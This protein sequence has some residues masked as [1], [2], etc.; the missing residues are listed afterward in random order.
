[1]NITGGNEKT[2]YYLG[3]GALDQEGIVRGSDDFKRYNLRAKL[4][5]D[6]NDWLTV[7]TNTSWTNRTADNVKIDTGRGF[8]AAPFF[9]SKTEDGL[10]VVGLGGDSSNPIMTSQSGSYNLLEVD[11]FETQ[12]FAK[13]K[14][15]K[16]LTFEEKVS[17]KRSHV[18]TES[19]KDAVGYVTL[20]VDDSGYTDEIHVS[21]T[22]TDRKLS[23]ESKKN[24]RITTQSFLRYKYEKNDHFFKGLLGFQTEENR[25]EGFSAGTFDFLNGSLQ[26]LDLGA[27]A[28]PDIGGGKGSKSSASEWSIVSF[29]G[30]LNYDYKSKYMAEVSFRYDGTSRFADSKKWGF[31]PSVS[32]GW[33]M[34]NEN[35]MQDVEMLDM[36]KLRASWGQLGDAF[37]VGQNSIYQTM[38]QNAGY[39]WPD[40]TRPGIATG[41]ASN[42]NITWETATV[43]NF[44]IDASFWK[45]KLGIQSEYFINNRTDILGTPDVAK[46]FG[47]G[48]PAQNVRDVRSWGWELSISHKNKIGKL[49]Y[50]VLV[51]LSDQKNKV[52]DLGSTTPDIGNRILDKGYAI[53]AHYGYRSDGLITSPEDLN[54][55]VSTYSLDGPLTPYVGS[56]KL[57]DISGPEGVPDGVIDAQYDREVID[58]NYNHYLLGGR[59]ALSYE[60]FEVSAIIEGVLDREIYFSGAQSTMAFSGGTGTPFT[61]QRDAFNPES[62]DAKAIM[63]IITPDLV[64]YDYSDYWIRKA[65]YVRMKNISLKYTFNKKLLKKVKFFNEANVYAS[66]ENPFMIWTNY[67]AH[68]YGWDPQLSPGAVNYPLAR[69]ISFGLNVRF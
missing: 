64:N 60:G 24:L 25:T 46:E 49:G 34:R 57:K 8:R 59:I 44:G 63:P 52:T 12:L 61:F 55:Y 26:D 15:L 39:V 67:F 68:D 35:F 23:Y 27:Q 65:N 18:N 14:L 66:I 21:P 47:L 13:I 10:F 1:V 40:G 48:A 42:P 3:L 11:I 31:F 62:P 37:K 36:L 2:S 20:E 41:S 16:G 56:V 51:N 28:D 30:R 6:V 50:E 58:D 45:G 53:D 69:T 33:N 32:L 38:N 9:P 17:F 4:E 7:G 5:T 22:S 43:M 29:L 54:N 19:W